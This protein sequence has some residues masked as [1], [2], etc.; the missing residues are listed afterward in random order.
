ML[1]LRRSLACG[2]ALLLLATGA[3]AQTAARKALDHSDYDIWKR[4]VGEALSA[5]G[6]AALYG[7]ESDGGDP[8][9]VVHPLAAAAEPLSIERGQS[10]AFSYDGRFVVF[11]LRPS[12]QAL[13]EAKKKRT[14]PADMPR[15]SL[16]ILDLRTGTIT[17]IAN[18]RDFKLPEK[19]GGWLAYQ[20]A[21]ERDSARAGQ[22][23]TRAG[24]AQPAQ[25]GEQDRPRRRERRKEAGTPLVVRNLETGEERRI[26][27]VRQYAFSRDG[28]RLAYTVSTRDGEGDGAYVLDLASGQTRALLT[29]KGEYR[30][31]VFDRAG[32]QVAFLSNRDDYEADQPAY[33]LYYWDGRAAAARAVAATGTRGIPEDWWVSEHGT[34]SFSE[35]GQ[36]L[37]FGTAPRPVPEPEDST[38]DDEKVVLDVWH[39]QDPYIQPMQLR[40]ADRERRRTYQAVVHLRDGRVVQLATLDVPEIVLA[41]RGD[42]DIALGRSNLPYRREVTWGRSGNDIYLVDIGT[43]ERDKVLE[44]VRGNVSISPEGKYL[45]WFDGEQRAWFTMDVGS[46]RV[47]NVSAGIP[48][49]VHNELDDTPDEP[50]PYGS[51]GWTRGDERFLVYDRNDIWAVDPAGRAAPRNITDGVGRR[52]DIRL[53]YVDLDPEERAIDPDR[54]LILAAFHYRTKASGFYRD[55]VRGDAPPVRLVMEDRSFGEPRRAE[56]AQVLML[57]RES[58]REFPDLYV[59]DPSFRELR[60]ISDANPQQAE[61]RWGTAELFEWRSAHGEPLQGVLYKPDD[62][63]PTRKY[64]LLVYF[65]ERLSQNLHSYVPPAA[66][67][68]SINI[69]FY[70]SRGY[71]VFTPDIPYR[72]GYPGES[73]MNAVVPGVLALI[74]EGF[75]D[76]KRIG[77]QGHSWGGYQI[78]YLITRTNLFAAAEA[79]APVSNM[80]S[81]YGGIRWSTGMSRMFQ[82]EQTQSRIGG[83]LWERPLQ[84]V[85]NSPIFWADKVQTP[86]L[87]MHNDQDGAVPWYQGIE[88]Y[89]ALRR[90][91]KPVWMINYNGEDHGL[92]KEHN[93][94]DWAIRMQQF[95][96]HFLLDA[97]PPVWLAEGI[98]ATEKGRTLGLELVTEATPVAQ[99]QEEGGH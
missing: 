98:P 39:W 4:I 40:Q 60:R 58:F 30:G 73:A 44:Y 36:R 54:D 79:G 42:A 27:H 66:H 59:T 61:Y 8:V 23:S 3:S 94:R 62:F 43:G 74:D 51:A 19:A 55:R 15:D 63:D 56:N 68:S 69:S 2:L 14:R 11:R 93:R 95:F 64:P 37:F 90:L 86:L 72:I 20:L 85:E 7:L 9:L 18:V 22:D 38:P 35:N 25:A 81:A 76:P 97:P 77:V 16:G 41:R 75:V 50:G 70:V 80:I 96:D 26:E 67:R 31:L 28:A 47:V 32:R 1:A 49:P 89:M 53:R 92:T 6:R 17:R 45:Y 5:D 99:A 13:D 29:G 34:L 52:E 78:A 46:R 65:Y 33:T 71:L 88:F 87:M 82:Y 83:T 21:E 48:H 91:N 12:K 24:G 57:T 10:G 84:F